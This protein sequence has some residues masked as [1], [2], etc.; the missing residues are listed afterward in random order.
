MFQIP[1]SSSVIL[2]S[3]TIYSWY[4]RSKVTSSGLRLHWET[5][6]QAESRD[7]KGHGNFLFDDDRKR[8]RIWYLCQLSSS[9]LAWRNLWS[10]WTAFFLRYQWRSESA[11]FVYL[12]ALISVITQMNTVF[13]ICLCELNVVNRKMKQIMT[14]K[15]RIISNIRRFPPS[16]YCFL[17]AYIY[18]W[19]IKIMKK[20]IMRNS[21]C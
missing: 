10:C 11:I 1:S 3:D 21:N 17:E 16:K 4:E 6:P 15:Y 14:R 7:K 9:A 2:P 20:M 8:R 19:V 18:F 13:Q 5:R 12:K